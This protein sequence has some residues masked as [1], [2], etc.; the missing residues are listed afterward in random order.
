MCREPEEV[1]AAIRPNTRM[2]WLETPANP[3]MK[4]CD[5]AELA[6]ACA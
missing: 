5:I 6:A 3:T 1:A 2:L 4:L